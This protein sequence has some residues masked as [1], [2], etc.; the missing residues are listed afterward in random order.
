MSWVSECSVAACS[1]VVQL[2][3][4]PMFSAQASCIDTTDSVSSCT[5]SAQ[6]V[7]SAQLQ[8]EAHIL[9]IHVFLISYIIF[10]FVYLVYCTTL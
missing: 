4:F 10:W 7:D 6:P 1:F 3:Q 8:G 2:A 9:T 5:A